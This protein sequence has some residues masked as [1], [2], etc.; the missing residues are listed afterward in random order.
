MAQQDPESISLKPKEIDADEKKM[1]ALLQI[2]GYKPQRAEYDAAIGQEIQENLLKMN[3]NLI[4][5]ENALKAA[6]DALKAEQWRAHHY[7][8][9]AAGQISSQFTENSDEYASLGYKKK[10][11]YKRPARKKKP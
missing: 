11:E 1:T 3:A 7:L 2:K 4:A 5:A 8:Q 10:M 9:G 6:G